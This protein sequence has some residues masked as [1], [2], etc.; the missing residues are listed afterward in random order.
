MMKHTTIQRAVNMDPS[1]YE[2]RSA[3]NRMNAS[4]NA[5]RKVV[6]QRSLQES[7]ICVRSVSASG[8]LIAAANAW[9]AI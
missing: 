3:L 5:Y 4:Y 8:V 7:R 9:A 1:N 6:Q 2:Y